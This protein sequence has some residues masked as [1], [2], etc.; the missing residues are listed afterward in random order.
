MKSGIIVTVLLVLKP[1]ILLSQETTVL[2]PNQEVRVEILKGQDNDSG[3]WRLRIDYVADNQSV[4]VIPEIDL[5]LIC[6]EQEFSNDLKLVRIG[7]TKLIKESYT[8]LHGKRSLCKNMAN[9][10]TV[11]LE[12]ANRAK[13]NIIIRAYNDG[14]A[15]RYELPDKG[16][17]FKG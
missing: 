14:V 4:V 3:N 7:K 12:N 16:G 2:S 15:F 8:A 6:N 9:E 11:Y 5:G 1:L 13:I 10:I 17:G